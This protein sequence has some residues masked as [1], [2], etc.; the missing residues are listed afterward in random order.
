MNTIRLFSVFLGCIINFIAYSQETVYKIK[1]LSDEYVE[2][3][4][5]SH[6]SKYRK[7]DTFKIKENDRIIFRH[8]GQCIRFINL[9][10]KEM[11]TIDESEYTGRY[12]RLSHFIQDHS[13]SVK[14]ISDNRTFVLADTL[15]FYHLQKGSSFVLNGEKILLP[16]HNTFGSYVV[17]DMFPKDSSQF[18]ISVIS[19]NDVT[20]ENV[21]IKIK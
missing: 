9:M 18:K 6:L 8:P 20:I 3:G 16:F 7:D 4:E 10:T 11:F 15:F 1:Y 17:P 2:I 21:T 14:G 5:I 13:L 19:S 12:D